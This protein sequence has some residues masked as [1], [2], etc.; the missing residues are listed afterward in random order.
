MKAQEI[1]KQTPYQ[2]T[3][4]DLYYLESITSEGGAYFHRIV[5]GLLGGTYEASELAYFTPAEIDVLKTAPTTEDL[6]QI[7]VDAISAGQAYELFHNEDYRGKLRRLRRTWHN[8]VREIEKIVEKAAGI[9]K[10]QDVTPHKAEKYEVGAILSDSWGYEQTNVDF[11]C[12]VRMTAKTVVL[13]PMTEIYRGT[14]DMSG[15]VMP[16][17]IKWHEKPISKRINEYTGFSMRSGGISGGWCTL[18]DGEEELT[19]SYA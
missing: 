18:W 6:A 17:G 16:G 5:D 14:G 19:T 12:V 3:D 9:E 4:K 2:T 10:M 15:K 1:K 8:E 13:L 7:A 11:Y